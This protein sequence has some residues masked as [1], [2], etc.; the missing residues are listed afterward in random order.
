MENASRIELFKFDGAEVRTVMRDGEPWFV[1][2]D[3]CRILGLANGR[4]VIA[5]FSEKLK[6]VANIYTLGGNQDM[7]ILSEAG[8]YKLV[9]RS[10]KPEA[11]RFTDWIASD[12]LPALRKTGTYTATAGNPDYGKWV[13]PQTMPEA[14]RLAA[15]ALEALEVA[16]PKVTFYDAVIADDSWLTLQRVAGVL[17]IP[18]LGR[19]KLFK[20]LRE[21]EIFTPA[22]VP[23]RRF[24][25]RGCFRLQEVRTPVG[26]RTQP[27]VS[28]KGIDYIL[29]RWSKAAELAVT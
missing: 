21:E 17:N 25:E 14:L 12:V 7:T 28:Q 19:T 5:Q 9:F 23:Y 20:F 15:T 16:R 27:M 8:V 3:A 18:R 24:I 29:K 1:A 11:E 4:E 10:R 22:N 26:V 6:G 13:I 2:S